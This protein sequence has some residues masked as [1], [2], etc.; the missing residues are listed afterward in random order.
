MEPERWVNLDF[1]WSGKGFQLAVPESDRCFEL[2]LSSNVAFTR[3]GRVF[4]LK[5][6]IH[7]LTRVP[8]ERQKILGLV[9]GKLPADQE[10]MYVQNSWYSVWLTHALGAVSAVICVWLRGKSS[11]WSGP[12]KG[13]KLRILPVCVHLLFG[14]DLNSQVHLRVRVFA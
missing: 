8:P 4:D 3:C 12:R 13:M 11:A 7:A 6:M 10:R 1:T 9:K 5:N 14:R 2:I